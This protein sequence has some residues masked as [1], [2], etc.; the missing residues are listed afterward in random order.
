MKY[1]YL[2]PRGTFTE[3]ALRSLP[4]SSEIRAEPRA[5]VPA[6]LAN[7]RSGKSDCAVV[8]LENSVKGVVPATLEELVSGESPLHIGAEV[9]LPVTFHLMIPPGQSLADVTTVL[10]HPHAHAQCRKWLDLHVPGADTVFSTSTAAAAR[11]VAEGGERHVAAIASDAAAQSY[12]LNLVASDIGERS[13]AVTRFIVVTNSRTF[14]PATGDDRTSLVV[15]AEGLAVGVLVDLLQQ[16]SSRGVNLTGIQSWPTGSGLGSYY[17]FLD[18]D[19]HIREPAVSEAVAAVRRRATSVH[20]L[21]SYPRHQVVR[22]ARPR[23]QMAGI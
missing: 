11:S 21:G 13:H 19:G 10:S 6:A 7:V 5:T 23:P 3:A 8:P 4:N 17:F 20:V 15:S 12:G 22:S 9:Q 14:Q 16:F 18:L 2:G 1:T